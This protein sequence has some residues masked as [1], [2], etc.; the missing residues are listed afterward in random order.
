MENCECG[1]E[2]AETR[3]IMIAAAVSIMQKLKEYLC[4]T[5]LWLPP[6]SFLLLQQAGLDCGNW[7]SEKQVQTTT[8]KIR[9]GCSRREHSPRRL[10]AARRHSRY[11]S[12]LVSRRMKHSSSCRIFWELGRNK[13]NF[14]QPEKNLHMGS[15]ED[16]TASHLQWRAGRF[17]TLKR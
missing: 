7:I 9:M 15:G 8:E 16:W 6:F 12:S 10:C 4:R 3:A 13:N 1:W 2:S 11:Y 5:I 17:S 14:K